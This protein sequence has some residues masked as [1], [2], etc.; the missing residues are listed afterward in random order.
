MN[1]WMGMFFANSQLIREEREEYD[2]LD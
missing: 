1:V 2:P